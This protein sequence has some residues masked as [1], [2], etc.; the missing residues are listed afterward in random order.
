MALAE[1]PSEQYRVPYEHSLLV[2]VVI[3]IHGF[4]AIQWIDNNETT[5]CC[6]QRVLCAPIEKQSANKEDG[7]A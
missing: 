2:T 1:T 7:S 5:L 3:V 6:L 4:P